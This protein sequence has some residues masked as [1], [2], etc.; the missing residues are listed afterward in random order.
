[1]TETPVHRAT[2]ARQGPIAAE[3]RRQARALVELADRLDPLPADAAWGTIIPSQ[4]AALVSMERLRQI[5]HEGHDPAGDH[6]YEGNELAWAAYCYLERAA[7][8][9]LPQADSS[10]PHVWPLARSAWK[11]KDSRVRNLV[12][13]AALVVAEVDRL[14]DL[15][16]VP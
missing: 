3:L 9:R 11:P 15:G 8:D 7:Q 5:E 4:G 16:E 13:G 1:M 2:A 12:I 6:A 10:V 14:L